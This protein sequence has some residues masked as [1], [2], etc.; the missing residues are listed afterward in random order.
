MQHKAAQLYYAAA[1]KKAQDK[2]KPT[3]PAKVVAVARVDTADTVDRELWHTTFQE[4]T[5][6]EAGKRE[7]PFE[8][9]PNVHQASP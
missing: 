9:L 5:E 7:N 1:T 6:T 8:H 2:T 4:T 3:E